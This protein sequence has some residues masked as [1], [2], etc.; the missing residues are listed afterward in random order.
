M[1]R[2]VESTDSFLNGLIV[3]SVPKGLQHVLHGVDSTRFEGLS[4]QIPQKVSNGFEVRS[5]GM[6]EDFYQTVG[7][8]DSFD[9][10]EFVARIDDGELDPRIVTADRRQRERANNVAVRELV[11][12]RVA[13]D[14]LDLHNLYS[15]GFLGLSTKMIGNNSHRRILRD[16]S[17]TFHRLGPIC[18]GSCI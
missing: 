8:R 14:V 12:R 16:S 6:I 13:I 18:Q 1:T 3:L 15:I 10:G 2:P 4:I 11:V 17:G 9:H 7:V 5:A